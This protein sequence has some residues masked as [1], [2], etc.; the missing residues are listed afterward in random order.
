[1]VW[2]GRD[3]T[4]WHICAGL[5]RWKPLWKPPG[6]SDVIIQRRERDL[7]TRPKFTWTLKKMC[8][9]SGD[10]CCSCIS[11][12]VSVSYHNLHL[13]DHICIFSIKSQIHCTTKTSNWTNLTKSPFNKEVAEV[14]GQPGAGVHLII[15]L[16]GCRGLD[17]RWVIWLSLNTSILSQNRKKALYWTSR[18]MTSPQTGMASQPVLSLCSH[19]RAQPFPGIV[20]VY[21]NFTGACCE[22]AD[23]ERMGWW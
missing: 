9:I 23:E 2:H 8:R 18:P 21:W 3:S 4:L 17:C 16:S 10:H 1:M 22:G 5:W 15:L 19:V 20:Q 6:V 12:R 13:I 7:Y 11:G 14:N